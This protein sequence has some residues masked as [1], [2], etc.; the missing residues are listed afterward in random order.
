MAL[1]HEGNRSVAPRILHDYIQTAGVLAYE[2]GDIVHFV[3]D[4]DP[5][6]VDLAVIRHFVPGEFRD[7][8]GEVCYCGLQVNTW[9][10]HCRYSHRGGIC[11]KKT[12]LDEFRLRTLQVYADSEALL[13]VILKAL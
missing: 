5:T 6:G 12:S 3:T 2:V 10:D 1:V 13:V 11:G 7:P 8:R 4:D 9:T